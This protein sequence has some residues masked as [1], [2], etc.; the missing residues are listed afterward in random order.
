MPSQPESVNP[1]RPYYIPPSIGETH[2]PI[3]NPSSTPFGSGGRHAASIGTSSSGYASKARD[4]LSDLDYKVS[5]GGGSPSMVQNVRD[6]IDE[7]IW[8]YTSVL[9]AQ[10][11]EVAKTILQVRSREVTAGDSSISPRDLLEKRPSYSGRS[12]H[13]VRDTWRGCLMGIFPTNSVGSMT[14]QTPRAKRWPTLPPTCPAHLHRYIH[15]AAA[16]E[17]ALRRRRS[18]QRGRNQ[19]HPSRT[20]PFRARTRYWM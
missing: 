16:S 13:D 9:M 18:R 15:E 5:S 14:N 3:S 6:L 19:Q 7:L 17:Q 4:M 8:K 20:L 1:L 10:P 11:F 2:D 12:A